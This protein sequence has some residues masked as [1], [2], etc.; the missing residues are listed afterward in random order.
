MSLLF[1]KLSDWSGTNTVLLSTLEYGLGFVCALALMQ[2][3]SRFYSAFVG[4]T[5]S[6]L[7]SWQLSLLFAC[8][9]WSVFVSV[10]AMKPEQLLQGV[11]AA[12]I[13]VSASVI[14]APFSIKAGIPAFLMYAIRRPV[15][16]PRT[17]YISATTIFV[18]SYIYLIWLEGASRSS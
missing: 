5:D 17:V 12:R 3:C 8:A 1:A 6:Q 2:L 4:R 9:T 18:T 11:D 14:L 13:I 7:S 16:Q 10:L 15:I